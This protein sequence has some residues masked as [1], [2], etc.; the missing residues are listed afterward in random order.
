MATEAPRFLQHGNVA[1]GLRLSLVA[2][3]GA[4]VYGASMRIHVRLANLSGADVD[5]PEMPTRSDKRS[6]PD[7]L[8]RLKTLQFRFS[9]ADGAEIVVPN[10]FIERKGEHPPAFPLQV[11]RAEEPT[12]PFALDGLVAGS[13]AL[14]DRVQAARAMTVTAEVPEIGLRSNPVTIPIET[15]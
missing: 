2:E 11:G 12:A 1:R 6:G 4:Y 10:A 14:F 3:P 15:R 13:G 8:G 9:F 7:A 5:V